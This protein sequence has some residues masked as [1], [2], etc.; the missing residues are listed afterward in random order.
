MLIPGK[1]Y[2]FVMIKELSSTYKYDIDT[3]MDNIPVGEYGYLQSGDILLY[4]NE[5]WVPN[6]KL[7]Q[8]IFGSKIIYYS[9]YFDEYIPNL[10]LPV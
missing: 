3:Y 8:F 10:L 4:C 1:L 7:Y 5:V 2:K 9:S 6:V